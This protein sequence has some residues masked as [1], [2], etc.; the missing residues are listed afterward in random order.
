ME[1]RNVPLPCIVLGDRVVIVSVWGKRLSRPIPLAELSACPSTSL[2]Q[3]PTWAQAIRRALGRCLECVERDGTDAWTKKALSL[4]SSVRQ[5]SSVE[6]R[7]RTRRRFETYP[8]ATWDRAIPR[9]WMQ[10]HNR[11]RHHCADGWSRWSITV[12]NNHNKRE[13]GRYATSCY[14]HGE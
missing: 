12:A 6:R 5:R 13:G 7:P 8:T 14:G 4:A 10:A 2:V 3:N 9:L 1:I 11:H